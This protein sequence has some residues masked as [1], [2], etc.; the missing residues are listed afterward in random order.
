MMIK[1]WLK[2]GITCFFLTRFKF[3]FLLVICNC[4]QKKFLKN[5]LTSNEKL[6]FGAREGGDMGLFIKQVH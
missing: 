5:I 4:K 2:V 6:E 1:R 3:N